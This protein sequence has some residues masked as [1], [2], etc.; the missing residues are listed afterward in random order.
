[1]KNK[2]I[3]NIVK[4]ALIAALTCVC[5]ML[6]AVPIPGGTG[7][8]NIGDVTVALA[9]VF[10]GPV[11]GFF[12]AAIGSALA[13]LFA[14]YIIYAPATFFIKGIMALT[15]AFLIKANAKYMVVP[16][17]FLAEAE[18]LGGYF[19]FELFLYG[20][21]TAT[22]GV[23][24][25]LVQGSACLVISVAVIYVLTANKRLRRLTYC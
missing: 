4:A 5:T 17:S 24:G 21:G 1:M 6:I 13:D 10:C 23:I 11:Y 15:V 2:H 20:K 19:I 25:N 22:A 8:I 9:G 7:F 16:A 14:G 12:A 18:M 3:T